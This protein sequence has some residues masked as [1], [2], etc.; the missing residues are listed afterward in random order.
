MKSFKTHL[1][2][3]I[4]GAIVSTVLAASARDKQ[5]FITVVRVQ[6]NATYS[7]GPNQPEHPLVAGKYLAPGSIVF[8][9]ENAIV[10][11]VL[12]KTID[13]PQSASV[14]TGISPAADYPVRGYVTY[15]PS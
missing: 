1:A 11:L 4:C 3:I 5:G 12:G 14:P 2:A 13:F 15:K 8:T 10:D 6:G 9:K 7:L